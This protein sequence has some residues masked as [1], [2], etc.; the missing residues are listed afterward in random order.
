MTIAILLWLIFLFR[1]SSSQN[2]PELRQWRMMKDK[3]L[4][5][6]LTLPVV[7]KCYGT[8]NYLFFTKSRNLK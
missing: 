4:D 5:K 7:A 1:R 6:L 8:I 2:Q 3:A